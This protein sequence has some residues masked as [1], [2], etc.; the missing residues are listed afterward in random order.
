MKPL[1][2]LPLIALTLAAHA[3]GATDRLEGW[4]ELGAG[5]THNGNG[6]FGEYRQPLQTSGLFGLGGLGL[7]WRDGDD[8]YRH[9]YL[10]A[11][12]TLDQLAF[13]SLHAR[14]GSYRIGFDVRQ[15]EALSR[16]PVST[17]FADRDG[18]QTLPLGYAGV[19]GAPRFDAHLGIRRERGSLDLMRQLGPWQLAARLASEHKEGGRAVGASERFGDAALLLAP[20]DQRHD[21]LDLDAAY[22]DGP[23][24]LNLR[25]YHSRFGNDSRALTYA[26]PINLAAPPRTLDLGPD[27]GFTRVGFDGAYRFAPTH[28]LSWFL[29]R[30]DARQ[31]DDFLQPLMVAGQPL[32]DSLDA[33]RVDTDLRIGLRDRPTARFGYRLQWDYRERDNRTDE[34]QLSPAGYAHL[35]DSTRRRLALDADYRLPWRMRW[36]GGAELRRVERTTRAFE[37]FRDDAEDRR[38]WSELRLPALG[39]LDWSLAVETTDRDSDLSAARRAELNLAAPVLATPDY[40]LAGRN[41]QYRLAVDL[42]LADS[43]MIAG[44]YRHLRDDFRND[45]YGLQGRDSDEVSLSLAWQARSD[46]ALNLWGQYQDFQLRQNGFE[47]HP[48]GAASHANARWRQYSDDRSRSAGLNLRWQVRSGLAAA[49]EFSHAENDSSYRSRWLEAADTGEA[50]GTSDSLPGVGV[51]VTRLDASLAWDYSAR[52]RVQLRYLYERMDSD[53]WAWGEA[54]FN[55]LAFGWNSPRHHAHALLFTVRHRLQ[56]TR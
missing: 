39:P 1:R 47:F 49:L 16:G 33:H 37:A 17:V 43:L 32:L 35:Y 56:L 36:K 51:D 44:Q 30:A 52:T 45:Y 3:W 2:A 26:N 21:S 23:W 18:V 15:F 20:V 34:V 12:A 9:G 8:P 28:Q 14:Q 42:P 48:S 24:T 50:A 6:R 7:A 22:Q 11:V 46:L 4:V 5:A 41:W 10:E 38:L 27:N 55:A 25:G 31:D 40:L 19:G 54:Q 13:E 29:S 53:D